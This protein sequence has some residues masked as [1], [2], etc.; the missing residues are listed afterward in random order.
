MNGR[1]WLTSFKL[2]RDSVPS[3]RLK[4][5]E[6]NENDIERACREIQGDVEPR[7]MARRI[8]YDKLI[9]FRVKLIGDQMAEVSGR[10]PIPA[11]EDGKRA[12]S[13]HQLGG[14]YN[15]YESIPF[16]LKVKI[17]A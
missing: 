4:R 3:F 6:L 17:A 16:S 15:L 14:M 9:D 1:G 5:P 10:I 7:G 2:T 11:A 12:N 8:I 13:T